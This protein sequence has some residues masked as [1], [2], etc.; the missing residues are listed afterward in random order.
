MELEPKPAEPL[1]IYAQ[2]S[3]AGQMVL[4][5]H[6]RVV[7]IADESAPA[8]EERVCHPLEALI[9]QIVQTALH[10]R[11]GWFETAS[12]IPGQ[13]H[14]RAVA[15][16]LPAPIAISVPDAAVMLGIGITSAWALVRRGEFDVLRVGRRTLVLLESLHAYARKLA[17]E[18]KAKPL[19]GDHRKRRN[20]SP[21]AAPRPGA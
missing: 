1:A 13:S 5:R 18:Q 3:L 8:L 4:E 14:T 7:G 11:S 10:S 12:A 6:H 17:A 9:Q 20:E 21:A 19:M 16:I 15:Q 2:H